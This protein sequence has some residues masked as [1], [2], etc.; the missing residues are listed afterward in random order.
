[1]TQAEPVILR[2]AADP[3]ILVIT[4]NRPDVRNAVNGQVAR[5]LAGAMDRLDGDPALR[6]GVLQGAE[7]G[8]SAGMDLKAFLGNDLPVVSGRG[9]GGF[10]QRP[11]AKPLIAAI[12]RF[13]VAGG[14]RWPW[15]AT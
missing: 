3:R 15:R 5:A 14:W 11:P 8:F 1:M 7:M 9:F 6:V 12:E 10:T 13:A 2:V 4:I